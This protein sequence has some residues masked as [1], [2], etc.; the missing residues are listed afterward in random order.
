MTARYRAWAEGFAWLHPDS[1]PSDV[2]AKGWLRFVD[3]V[4]LFLDGDFAAAAAALGWGPHDLFGCDHHRPFAQIASPPKTAGCWR[5]NWPVENAG[6]LYAGVPVCLW[7]KRTL[8]PHRGG[9]PKGSA[10]RAIEPNSTLRRAGLPSGAVA[11]GIVTLAAIK[12]GDPR[13]CTLVSSGS[14]QPR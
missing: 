13:A 12:D 5:G 7:C 9:S 10:R 2:P 11:A 8:A 4:G 3:D 14:P 1:P 6:D